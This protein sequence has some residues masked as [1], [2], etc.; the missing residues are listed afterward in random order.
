MLILK[1]TAVARQEGI[2]YSKINDLIRS[3]VLTPPEKDS[4][5]DYYWLPKDV[6]R[7]R[8]VLAARKQKRGA[9]PLAS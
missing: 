5:G 9:K 8:R 1:T 4:S 7:L 6:E 2:H 3:G